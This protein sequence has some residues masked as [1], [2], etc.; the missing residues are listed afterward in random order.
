M[1]ILTYSE[2][3]HSEFPA[4]KAQAKLRE[5]DVIEAQWMPP[6]VGR[7]SSATG[8]RSLYRGSDMVRPMLHIFLS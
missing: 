2:N 7:R 3:S 4:H 6:G 5:A 1:T 8:K